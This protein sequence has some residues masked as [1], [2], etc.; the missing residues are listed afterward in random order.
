MLMEVY[1]K[2]KPVVLCILDGCGVREESDGNAFLNAL[3]SVSSLTPHPSRIHNT[4]GLFFIYTSININIITQ[5]K[6]S[7]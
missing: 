6:N 4:T 2:N 5:K 3:P 7:N 1:M